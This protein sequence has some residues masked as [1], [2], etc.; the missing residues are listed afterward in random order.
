[1]LHVFCAKNI[2][3]FYLF[4]LYYSSWAPDS[5]QRQCKMSP[6][7]PRCDW[8]IRSIYFNYPNARNV[9]KIHLHQIQ[10]QSL[11]QLNIQGRDR[12]NRDG[13]VYFY[14]L[15]CAVLLRSHPDPRLPSPQLIPGPVGDKGTDPVD[16]RQGEIWKPNRNVGIVIEMDAPPNKVL[17]DE[18][19]DEQ[20]DQ[21]KPS[22]WICIPPVSHSV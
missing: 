8:T 19:E 1:M 15:L 12:D 7:P 9:A 11:T 4:S 14:L 22:C 6:N 18:E 5:E 16:E 13:F 10:I 2:Y 20:W 17:G 3:C 21:M